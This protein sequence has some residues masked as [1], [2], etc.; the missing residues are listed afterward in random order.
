MIHEGRDHSVSR[1]FLNGVKN[2]AMGSVGM[3]AI[4]APVVA[5]VASQ[6]PDFETLKSQANMGNET[7]AAAML[8]EDLSE[9]S[10]AMSDNL[11]KLTTSD[12]DL[13]VAIRDLKDLAEGDG[14]PDMFTLGMQSDGLSKAESR[15]WTRDELVSAAEALVA[16]HAEIKSLLDETVSDLAAGGMEAHK[17][18]D[19]V[20][21]AVSAKVV[22]DE[23]GM[24][25]AVWGARDAFAETFEVDLDAAMES[26]PVARMLDRADAVIKDA[27]TVRAPERAASGT[28]F[29]KDMPDDVRLAI[30]KVDDPFNRSPDAK[31]GPEEGP[32]T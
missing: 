9:V 27:K 20:K 10:S 16:S 26:G 11:D 22:E 15:D 28:A 18:E 31:A 23:A 14:V 17:A 13:R 7:Y 19:L 30:M 12:S 3:L 4:M 6:S 2:Y 29:P 24:M 21:A 32:Q 8:Y 25:A 5:V 1:G